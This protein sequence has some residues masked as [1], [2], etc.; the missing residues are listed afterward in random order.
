MEPMNFVIHKC[1]SVI[2]AKDQ[3]HGLLMNFLF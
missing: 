2:I 3:T 1:S